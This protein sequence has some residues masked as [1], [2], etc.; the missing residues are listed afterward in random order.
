MPILPRVIRCLG[1]A[2]PTKPAHD[3]RGFSSSYVVIVGTLLA[4]IMLTGIIAFVGRS[5]ASTVSNTAAQSLAEHSYIL[6][7]GYGDNLAVNCPYLDAEGNVIAPC[8]DTTL[9]NEAT[10]WK[11]SWD[12]AFSET[13]PEA[14]R[15]LMSHFYHSNVQVTEMALEVNENSR[16]V[17]ARITACSSLSVVEFYELCSTSQAIHFI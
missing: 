16:S 8:K 12:N 5:Q 14:V 11:C 6:C 4:S 1:H 9:P 3:N 2:Q 10:S 15:E 17:I 7:D 13:V